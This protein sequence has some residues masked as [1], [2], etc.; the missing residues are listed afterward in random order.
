M[1]MPLFVTGFDGVSIIITYDLVPT[2]FVI[3]DLI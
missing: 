3:N 2:F 1:I